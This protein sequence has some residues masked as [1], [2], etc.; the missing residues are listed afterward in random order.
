ML[1]NT[2]ENTRLQ[3]WRTDGWWFGA[4]WREGVATQEFLCGD[5]T[6][7]IETGVGYMNLY[8]W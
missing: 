6:V 5:E 4:R 7:C 3:W 2:L 8:M 1:Y